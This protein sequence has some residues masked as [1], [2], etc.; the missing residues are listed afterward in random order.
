MKRRWW[1]L[2][3][4]GVAGLAIAWVGGF[5]WFLHFAWIVPPPPPAADGIVVLTGGADRVETG[6]RLLAAGKA[7]QLLISGVGGTADFATLARSAGASPALASRVSLGRDATT[8]RGNARETARWVRAHHIRSL[9]VV[10]AG[11][12]M[13]RALAD[14]AHAMPGVVLYA[15]PVVPAAVAQP[16]LAVLRLLAGEYTKFLATKAGLRAFAPGGA[17]PAAERKETRR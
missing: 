17:E 9:I 15:A 7:P 8:T 2:V 1:K 16:G 6:L 10:T 3:A 13:P 11:Y 5:L 14:L 12:H 4:G